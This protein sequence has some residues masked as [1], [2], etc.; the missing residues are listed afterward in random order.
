[1]HSGVG[2]GNFDTVPCLPSGGRTFHVIPGSGGG[3]GTADDPFQGI[4]AAQA[5]ALPGDIFWVQ[6]GA[7][8]GEVIF[9]A[10]GQM[11]NHVVWKAAADGEALVGSI[12]VSGDFIWLEG[13][14][15]RDQDNALLTYSAPEGVVVTRNSFFNNHY[16]VRLNHGGSNWHITDNTIIGDQIPGNCSGDRC[17][18]GEGVELEHTSGHVVAYNSISNVADGISHPHVNGDIFNI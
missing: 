5:V 14:T 16:A 11:D 3:A 2:N 10:S 13:L 1:M 4:A 7:Y 18:S 12:R 15:V 17:F 8:P 9:S 6:A